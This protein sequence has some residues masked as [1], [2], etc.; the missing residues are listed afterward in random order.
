MW[1]W[2]ARAAAEATVELLRRATGEDLRPGLVVSIATAADLLQW[3]PHLHL[4][5]SDGGFAADG[6]FVGRPLA[7]N[8]PAEG[9]PYRSLRTSVLE[10]RQRPRVQTLTGQ[11]R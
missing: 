3:H 7:P 9:S 6:I 10:F 11:A 5:A 2:L 8:R 1:R 4:L